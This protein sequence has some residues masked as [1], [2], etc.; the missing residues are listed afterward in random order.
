MCSGGFRVSVLALL[1]FNPKVR[2]VLCLGFV[3]GTLEV[4]GSAW[5]DG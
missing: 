2:R 5:E 4:A 1:G 3:L